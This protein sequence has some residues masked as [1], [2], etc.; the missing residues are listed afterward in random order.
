MHEQALRHFL[1]QTRKGDCWSHASRLV[2]LIKVNRATLQ[3]FQ[4]LA[5]RS[6]HIHLREGKRTVQRETQRCASS[7]CF[8]LCGNRQIA[9]D[10]KTSVAIVCWH[11]HSIWDHKEQGGAPQGLGRKPP[12]GRIKISSAGGGMNTLAPALYSNEPDIELQF[13]N[14]LPHLQCLTELTRQYRQ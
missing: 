3:R 9:P 13:I 6:N 8:D 5:T 14:Q 1:S 7:Y 12:Y 10:T 4:H 2:P 11:L